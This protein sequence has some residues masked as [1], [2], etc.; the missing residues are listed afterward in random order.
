M[1]LPEKNT[2]ASY[3]SFFSAFSTRVRPAADTRDT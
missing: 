1:T 2:I 3:N